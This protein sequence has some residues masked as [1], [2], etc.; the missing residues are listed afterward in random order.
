MLSEWALRPDLPN[1]FGSQLISSCTC[2]PDGI[3]NILRMQLAA[4]HGNDPYVDDYYHQACLA[5]NSS[6][7]KLRHHFCPT[8]L[9]DLP[10][11]LMPTQ[12]LM[13]I[14]MLMLLAEFLSLR[15]KDL[16]PFLKSIPQ[17]HLL[18]LNRLHPR[19]L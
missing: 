18:I 8:H 15:F 17:T 2:H 14:F 12:S 11:T 7:A 4:T 3:E 9:R 1:Y 10:P 13:L 16:V 6:G 19:N 5:K